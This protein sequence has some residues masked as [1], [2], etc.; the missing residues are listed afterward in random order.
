[1]K[2]HFRKYNQSCY[3]GAI[4]T[5]FPS[6]MSVQLMSTLTESAVQRAVETQEWSA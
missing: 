1:M 3:E 6:Q 4:G 5:I 2:F